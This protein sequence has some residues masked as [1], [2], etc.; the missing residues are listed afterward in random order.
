[1][2]IMREVVWRMMRVV[3]LR[4]M[5]VMVI[6]IMLAVVM[7]MMRAVV[8]RVIPKRSSHVLRTNHVFIIIRL[9]RGNF[10]QHVVLAT[11]RRNVE[12]MGMNVR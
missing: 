2:R 10:Y 6:R 9:S 8:M 4:M 1:M 11:L 3:V 12:T 5:W 7:K